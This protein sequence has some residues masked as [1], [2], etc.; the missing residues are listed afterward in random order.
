MEYDEHVAAVERETELMA[1][2]FA[3]APMT[4]RVP[5][6]PEWTL[7]ELA[8]H[9]GEFT[10]LWTHVLC[11]GTGR[12]KT[13]YSERPGEGDVAGWY[14]GLAA[15]LL[16]ELRATPADTTVWTWVPADKTARFI[17]R[18]CANEL[19]IHRYDAE[20][21]SGTPGPVEAALAADGIDEIFVMSAAWEEEH[22][23]S[24]RTL[25][26]RPTDRDDRWFITLASEGPQAVHDAADGA[27]L[28]LSGTTSDLELTLF[29]RPPLGSVEQAGDAEALAA[30]YRDFTF[31]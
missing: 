16:G 10:G 5:T 19:A 13:P 31:G 27:D 3:A 9:V 8:S 26:V 20:G 15:S 14:R 4:A 23:G 29:Q 28:T 6:C 1:A 7:G 18:R 24:G 21:A 2:A 12:P 25:S 30:W 11:E 17:A 22:E